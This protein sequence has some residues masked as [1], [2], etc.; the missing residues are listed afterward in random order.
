MLDKNTFNLVINSPCIDAGK[1]KYELN[2]IVLLEI[3]S[4]YINGSAPDIGAIE[5]DRENKS[6]FLKKQF[7]VD[8][9]ED[10]ILVSPINPTDI[11]YDYH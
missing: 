10:M 9:G 7:I 11:V 2:G 6:A 1:D 5:Y 3:A 4:Q 8:A